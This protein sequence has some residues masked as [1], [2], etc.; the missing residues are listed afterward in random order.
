MAEQSET[1][2]T[3]IAKGRFFPILLH[4]IFHKLLYLVKFLKNIF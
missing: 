3:I 2:D 1:E 4:V